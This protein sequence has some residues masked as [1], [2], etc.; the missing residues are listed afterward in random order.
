M[1]NENVTPLSRAETYQ[2]R[3]KAMLVEERIPHH[4]HNGIIEYVMRGRPTGDFL[5]SVLSNELKQSF[6][7]ADTENLPALERYVNL[8]LQLPYTCQGSEQKYLDWV[9]HRGL[10]GLDDEGKQ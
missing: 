7:R 1:S 2:A 3:L 9:A 5:R 10:L 8:M 4:M 6:Q